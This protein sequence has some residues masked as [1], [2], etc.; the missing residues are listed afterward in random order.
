MLQKAGKMKRLFFVLV[1]VLLLVMA[2]S[3][4][5]EKGNPTGPE[6]ETPVE[7]SFLK[8]VNTAEEARALITDNK[9]DSS[10][11]IL[12]VRTPNEYADGHLE[13]AINI[14]LN[15]GNFENEI[16]ILDKNNTYL[17]Y[18]RSGGRSSSAVSI[19]QTAGFNYIYNFTGSMIAWLNAGYPVEKAG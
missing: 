19:M 6:S 8:V 2:V 10:F 3:C 11:I 12:D 18:C 17:V 14:S 13:G 16:E 5:R 7:E 15:S 9:D 1:T 4:S